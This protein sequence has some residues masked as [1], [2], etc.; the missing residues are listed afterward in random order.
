MLASVSHEGKL[1]GEDQ[2]TEADTH[3]PTH[4]MAQETVSK[5]DYCNMSYFVYVNVC[6]VACLQECICKCVC[7]WFGG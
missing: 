4:T 1:G 6:I 5:L 2:Q 3:S 7:V